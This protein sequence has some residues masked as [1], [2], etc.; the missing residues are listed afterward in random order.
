MQDE[1]DD[2]VRKVNRPDTRRYEAQDNE[3]HLKGSHQAGSSHE[4]M[5]KERE[6]ENK[7]ESTL[8]KLDERGG[9][10]GSETGG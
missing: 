10:T 2:N 6:E 1:N 7:D 5:K 4:N 9:G 3:G 8:N